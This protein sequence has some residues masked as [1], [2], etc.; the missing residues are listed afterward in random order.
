M[1]PLTLLRHGFYLFKRLPRVHQLQE[2]FF[3]HL[4]TDTDKHFLM[5]SALSDCVNDN[6]GHVQIFHA[7]L[8]LFIITQK[9][10]F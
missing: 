9:N 2:L 6:Q 5:D 1:A 4:C 3:I 10:I 8:D 7:L